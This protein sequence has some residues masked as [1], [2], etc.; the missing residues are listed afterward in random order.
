MYRN[1]TVHVLHMKT[2]WTCILVYSYLFGPYSTQLLSKLVQG[3]Y[4][5]SVLSV[6]YRNE[7]CCGWVTTVVIQSV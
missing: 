7:T 3:Q 5:Y 2:H 6:L 4:S 1:C